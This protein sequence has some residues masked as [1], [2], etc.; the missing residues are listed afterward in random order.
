MSQEM[1]YL[2]NL[3]LEVVFKIK[4]NDTKKTDATVQSVFKYE[5][6]ILE[7]EDDEGVTDLYSD[8]KLDQIVK[9]YKYLVDQSV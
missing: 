6:E 8:E 9:I 7:T 2:L 4:T 1:L 5:K 3:S